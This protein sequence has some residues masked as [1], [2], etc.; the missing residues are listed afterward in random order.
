MGVLGRN[1]I[2]IN[3]NTRSSKD[4]TK[5]TKLVILFFSAILFLKFPGGFSSDGTGTS[6]G[7]FWRFRKKFGANSEFAENGEGESEETKTSR[8]IMVKFGRASK[9]G[10]GN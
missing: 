3:I 1:N 8:W 4:L 6:D 5:S 7:K 2:S 10:S 9:H